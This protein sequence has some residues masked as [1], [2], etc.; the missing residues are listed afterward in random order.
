MKAG[1][2]F[3]PATGDMQ[4]GSLDSFNGG[5]TGPES[6]SILEQK[7]T[8]QCPCLPCSVSAYP[9]LQSP[10]LYLLVFQSRCRQSPISSFQSQ[11]PVYISPFPNRLYIFIKPCLGVFEKKLIRHRDWFDGFSEGCFDRC[12]R[13]EIITR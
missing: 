13:L 10:S 3:S 12:M 2:L 1:P 11:V 9:S 6:K 8:E 5:V 7:A 4:E